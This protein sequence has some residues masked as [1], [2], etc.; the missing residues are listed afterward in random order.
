MS[1]LKSRILFVVASQWLSLQ[2]ATTQSIDSYLEIERQ[3]LTNVP[4]LSP[5]PSTPTA[6]T[7]AESTGDRPSKRARHEAEE[8]TIAG[9][10]PSQYLRARCPL[11]FGGKSDFVPDSTNFIV[12]LDACFNQKHNKQT[13]D[14]KLVHPR[15]VFL[16]QEHVDHWQNVV[17]E[18][19]PSHH[20]TKPARNSADD[21]VEEG[22]QVPKSVLDA[23]NDS[24][25]AADGYREK[26]S[27]QF[28]DSTALMGLLCRHD[29]VL[30]LVNMTTPGERQH[31]ALALLDQLFNHIP[32]TST[33]GVLY[34][35][36]CQLQRSCVKWGFMKNHLPRITSG[37][38]K[39]CRLRGDYPPNTRT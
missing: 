7:E 17:E 8:S 3:G 15:S 2:Q 4:P 35:I 21:E 22:M 29:R 10:R 34:D 19:R 16:P 23:C 12:C 28:F 9:S 6:E 26:A 39:S 31:Y 32:S 37:T 11:Y 38:L 5:A 30:W 33:V 18:Q 14:P 25:T 13:R 1:H 36:A 24:F 27:T 20:T